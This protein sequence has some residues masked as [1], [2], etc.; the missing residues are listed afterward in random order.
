MADKIGRIAANHNATTA[1]IALAWLLRR[2]DNILLIPGTK[3]LQHLHE[4]MKAAEIALSAEEF[5]ELAK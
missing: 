1:Q 4:N 5:E 2:A 3:S